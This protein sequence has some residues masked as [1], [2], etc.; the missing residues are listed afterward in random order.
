M[1]HFPLGMLLV[2]LDTSAAAAV[3]IS[4]TTKALE[5]DV[6]ATALEKVQKL[7]KALEPSQHEAYK[8][9]VAKHF[10]NNVI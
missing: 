7:E 2:V 1:L 9:E 4:E 5:T 10:S 3:T 8:A 6:A